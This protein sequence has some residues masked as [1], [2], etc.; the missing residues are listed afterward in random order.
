MDT[1]AFDGEN[2]IELVEPEDTDD[3]NTMLTYS[4]FPSSTEQPRHDQ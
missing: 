1:N 4:G 2:A 3:A